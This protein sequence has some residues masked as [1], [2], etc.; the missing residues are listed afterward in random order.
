VFLFVKSDAKRIMAPVQGL[1]TEILHG[2]LII[3]N[4]LRM[5]TENSE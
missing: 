5:V 4:R 3:F 1:N 2:G